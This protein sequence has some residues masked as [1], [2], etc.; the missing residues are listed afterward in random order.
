M[1]LLVTGGR[2]YNNE[3]FLFAT[4]DALH[5]QLWTFTAVAHGQCHLGGADFLAG[6]WARERGIEEYRFP[7]RNSID[8]PWP[9]AG[10]ARNV[11]MFH[12]FMPQVV[13]AFRGNGGTK[14]MFDYALGKKRLG[15]DVEVYDARDD[16]YCIVASR[17][18]I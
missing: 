12:A 7:V 10:N 17:V 16:R 13:V 6:K 8:G 2:S 11:R 9:R 14:H 18:S 3:R 4:L 5:T 15:Y 1:R